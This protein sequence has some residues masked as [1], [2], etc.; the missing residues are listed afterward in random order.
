VC[1]VWQLSK[2]WANKQLLRTS[3]PLAKL[4]L[5]K[6]IAALKELVGWLRSFKEKAL[7]AGADINKLMK[8]C[9]LNQLW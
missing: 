9:A 4:F 7:G 2:A 6:L 3:S 5:F 1:A 8:A